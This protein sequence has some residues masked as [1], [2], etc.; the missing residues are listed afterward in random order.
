MDKDKNL[1]GKILLTFR[2]IYIHIL[3]TINIISLLTAIIRKKLNRN[4]N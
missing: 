1:I 3:I 2:P 4:V